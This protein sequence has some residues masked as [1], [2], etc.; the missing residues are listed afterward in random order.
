[1]TRTPR[2]L[3]PALAAAALALTL[4]LSACISLLPKSEP[5][6]L[7]RF[8][9][10]PA[11]AEPMVKDQDT[12]A[13]FQA[14]AHF[15]QEA[16]GDRIL[17]LSNGKAAYIAET[18]WVAPASVLWRQAVAAAFEADPGRTRL[19]TRGETARADYVL[20]L[21]VRSFETRYEAGPKA[22]PTVVVRVR[23]V[24]TRGADSALAAERI[25]EQRIPAADNRVGAI[26]PAYDAA[27]QAVLAE[28]VAWAN[29][30]ATPPA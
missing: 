13:L 10:Q 6:Q 22:A 17:T 26:V 16:A 8:G 24:L 1:M 15:P 20:R 30:T 27:V 3:R 18:R 29:E 23:G 11:A 14:N 7:Y 21:D 25:F 5:V 4:P 28:V 9:V 19:V 12:V 2:P